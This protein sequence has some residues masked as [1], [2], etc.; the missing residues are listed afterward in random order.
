MKEVNIELPV[1]LHSNDPDPAKL[2]EEIINAKAT[3]M[4]FYGI[5]AVSPFFLDEKTQ[6]SHIHCVGVSYLCVIPYAQLIA[7]LSAHDPS[8]GHATLTA[9]KSQIIQPGNGIIKG[10]HGS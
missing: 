6:L 1:I 2:A 5:I 7:I 9:K 10:L 4:T 3:M 8:K